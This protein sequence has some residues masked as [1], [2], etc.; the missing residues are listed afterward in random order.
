MFIAKLGLDALSEMGF[1]YLQERY[2]TVSLNIT[3]SY[4]VNRLR[5]ADPIIHKFEC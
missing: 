3:C 2:R 1:R 4:M 5:I